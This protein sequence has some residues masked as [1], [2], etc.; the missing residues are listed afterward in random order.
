MVTLTIVSLLSCYTDSGQQKT[1]LDSQFSA[2][3][4]SSPCLS[5]SVGSTP[6]GYCLYKMSETVKSIEGIEPYCDWAGDWRDDCIYNWVVTK[7]APDSGI[8]TMELLGLCGDIPDCAFRVVEHRPH[9]DITETLK[10]CETHVSHNLRAC[11]L[12]AMEQWL[13]AEPTAEEVAR[14][15]QLPE[16]PNPNVAFY[17]AARVHCD[18]VG[19]CRG[20]PERERMCLQAVRQLESRERACPRK[21]NTIWEGNAPRAPKIRVEQA[22]EKAR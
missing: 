4:P 18:G 6:F 12:H 13:A 1:A 22:V 14:L 3:H 8:G 5:Y 19:T 9:A 21:V 20:S 17:L 10:L 11:N 16:A 15:M 7:T 2:A